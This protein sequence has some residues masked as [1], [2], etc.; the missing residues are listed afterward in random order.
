M[1][2]AA[3][4]QE[5]AQSSPSGLTVTPPGGEGMT[6]GQLQEIGREVGIPGDLVARA[7]KGLE[8]RG[9]ASVRRFLGLTIGVGRTVSLQRR[10]TDEEWERLVVDLRETFDARGR[11]KDEGAFRQW[12]NG[13]L[14]A[15]LEPTSTGHQ[16]RLK[17]MK[18]DSYAMISAGLAVLGFGAFMVIAKELFG[19]ASNLAPAM[20]LGLAG[21]AM[22]GLGALRLPG[23]AKLRQKQMEEIAARLTDPASK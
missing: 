7:A 5:A 8:L 22:V 20:L 14:Q 23:W 15:L 18:G 12:T 10:L 2:S 21:S 9:R 1:R 6:L 16:L 19:G 3:E 13:N 17:T 4:L 11:L